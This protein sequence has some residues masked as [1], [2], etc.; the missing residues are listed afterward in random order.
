MP[1][2]EYSDRKRPKSRATRGSPYLL[3]TVFAASILTLLV[4][5]VGLL[6]YK[7]KSSLI[8]TDPVTL[9]PISLPPTSVDVVVLDVSEGFSEAQRLQVLN[10]LARV[11]R[12]VPRLG[13]IEVFSI[14]RFD[15][16][17]AEPVFHA[18]NPGTGDDLNELY[19][20]PGRANR[21]W[22]TF[23]DRLRDE[24]DKSMRSAGQAQSPIFEAIQATSARTFG[25][26]EF[27]DVPK[28]LW[29]VSDLIQ[30]V[31][32][33]FSMYRGLPSFEAFQRSDYYNGVRSDLHGV[34]VSLLY[35]SRSALPFTRS[36]HVSFWEEFFRA[37]GASVNSVDTIF[38]DK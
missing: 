30:H 20:N 16:E 11:H 21:R 38:G 29:I 28:Q 15:T 32:D 36:H 24:I 7:A 4:A 26:P 35:L 33:K 23:A 14:T 17:L 37:Q 18:C 3:K 5:A 2:R 19:Q 9:C 31:P 13:L 1:L 34:D 6:A 27:D 8:E 10:Q 12:N 22:K 25:R